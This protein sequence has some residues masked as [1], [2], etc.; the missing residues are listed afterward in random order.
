M[1]GAAAS[2]GARAGD[3]EPPPIFVV[4]APGASLAAWPSEEPRSTM[5]SNSLGGVPTRVL[6]ALEA[7]GD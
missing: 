6:Q 3:I 2:T 4:V 5:R 7:I 1:V